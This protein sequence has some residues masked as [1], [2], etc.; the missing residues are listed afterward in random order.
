MMTSADVGKSPNLS[1]EPKPVFQNSSSVQWLGCRH[2]IAKPDT[3]IDRRSS[4]KSPI[5]EW[6]SD[7]SSNLNKVTENEA[8]SAV[9]VASKFFVGKLE[10]PS[11]D[12]KQ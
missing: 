8:S 3:T 12:Y 6:N 10:T 5:A 7:A 11:G 2:Q 4:A 9:T 1:H